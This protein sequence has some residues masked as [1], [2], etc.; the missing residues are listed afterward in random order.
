MSGCER[1]ILEP[2]SGFLERRRERRERARLL[3]RL[4]ECPECR[5]PWSEHPGT[6]NDL[7]G[8]CGECAYEFEH[9]QRESSAPGC[10][11]LCPALD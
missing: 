10:R 9:D 1:G 5:H 11:L 3:R 6:E 4:G 8:M 2:V 7:N